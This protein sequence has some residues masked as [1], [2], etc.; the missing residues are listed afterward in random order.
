VDSFATQVG[1]LLGKPGVYPIDHTILK[2]L[3]VLVALYLLWRTWKGYDWVA[4]AGWTLLATSVTA[5][6]V[7][8][9]YLLWP[10]PLAA[11]ARDR[12][13]LWG[14]L[15]VQGLFLVHQLPPLFVPQ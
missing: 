11:I 7:Q 12:R 10:L 6:W 4:A 5:T 15:V 14:T 9:W 3:L 1:H 8:A 13:V 2:V